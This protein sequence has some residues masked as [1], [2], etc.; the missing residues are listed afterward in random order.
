MRLV[1]ESRHSGSDQV[2]CVNAHTSAG[3]SPD[4]GQSEVVLPLSAE[5]E[6]MG[7][8]AFSKPHPLGV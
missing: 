3:H 5:Q 4:D 7:R 1:P 8:I 6:T 2:I